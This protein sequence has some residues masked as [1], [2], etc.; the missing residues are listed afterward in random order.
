MSYGVHNVIMNMCT[1]MVQ[2]GKKYKIFVT[3]QNG[4]HKR[5]LGLIAPPN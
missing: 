4:Q 2:Y 3:L 1:F 5:S